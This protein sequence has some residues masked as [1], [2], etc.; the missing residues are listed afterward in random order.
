[1]S[2]EVHTKI[3]LFLIVFGISSTFRVCESS[4]KSKAVRVNRQNVRH[5]K[6]SKTV[7]IC[8]R[9]YLYWSILLKCNVLKLQ[10]YCI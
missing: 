9:S 7:F 6:E 2:V 10:G 3:K 5:Y 4:S 1:M 8:L